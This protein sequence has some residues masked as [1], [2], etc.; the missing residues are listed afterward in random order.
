MIRLKTTAAALVAL[1]ATIGGCGEGL[2]NGGAGGGGATPQNHCLLDGAAPLTPGHASGGI[3]FFDGDEGL[4]SLRGGDPAGDWSVNSFTL[5]IPDSASGLVVV[6]ESS[7]HGTAWVSMTDDGQFSL[8]FDMH[9][10]ISLGG[11]E[12][13][14][15]GP[16]VAGGVGAYTMGG[17]AVQIA[18]DCFFSEGLDDTG[19]GA[20]ADDS[21]NRNVRFEQN[22][23]SGQFLVMLRSSYG[24]VGLLVDVT[25][26]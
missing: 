24:E 6:D 21:L 4:P 17:D 3:E 18:E 15:D 19:S 16:V 25:R 10:T 26:S 23:N 13:L 11:G 2:P 9:I 22:G 1:M 14:M 20:A 8:A 12:T 5:F 7:L